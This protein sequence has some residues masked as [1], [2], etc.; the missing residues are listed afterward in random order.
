VVESGDPSLEHVCGSAAPLSNGAKWQQMPPVTLVLENARETVS[1][2]FDERGL[3]WGYLSG[4]QA[5]WWRFVAIDRE[6]TARLLRTVK[7]RHGMF[8]VD[9]GRTASEAATDPCSDE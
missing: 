8:S 3:F 9:G 2:F 1:V 4:Q 6:T 7:G 5:G